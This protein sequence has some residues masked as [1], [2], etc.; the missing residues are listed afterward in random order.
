MSDQHVKV[1]WRKALEARPG[2]CFPFF[3][4]Q[5]SLSKGACRK[6]SGNFLHSSW[7]PDCR[8]LVAGL[9]PPHLEQLPQC[10]Q[11]LGH[12]AVTWKAKCFFF[13]VFV[14]G[15]G[16]NTLSN[17]DKESNH[18]HISLWRSICSRGSQL[19]GNAPCKVIISTW[20]VASARC[21]EFKLFANLALP[22]GTWRNIIQKSKILGPGSLQGSSSAT[23]SVQG[24]EPVWQLVRVRPRQR[25]EM[26]ADFKDTDVT[27]VTYIEIHRDTQESQGTP[28]SRPRG[29]ICK[30]HELNQINMAGS[31]TK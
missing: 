7:P 31:K 13:F 8:L 12:Q 18:L 1:G 24:L 17:H 26:L 20:V 15:S 14:T 29:Q 22:V 4:K 21:K 28:S 25:Q 23:L 19:Q 6:L 5:K 16:N 10:V 2:I 27:D 9:W 3:Y 30:S 11:S